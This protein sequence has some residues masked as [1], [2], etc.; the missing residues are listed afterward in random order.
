MLGREFY[1]ISASTHPL[2]GTL[3]QAPTCPTV[4]R[5]SAEMELVCRYMDNR[6]HMDV[7]LGAP[8]CDSEC[9]RT[10]KENGRDAGER[11]ERDKDVEGQRDGP[12]SKER[13]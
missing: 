8:F 10:S 12:V 13:V 11:L 3:V 2:V 5:Y 9:W 7:G 6:D 4:H 1:Q